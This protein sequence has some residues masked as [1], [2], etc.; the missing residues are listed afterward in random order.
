MREGRGDAYCHRGRPGTMRLHARA[1]G[2][3]S[4]GGKALSQKEESP[5]HL[6]FILS[7]K[8]VTP[9]WDGRQG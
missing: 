6:V 7:K 4:I 1:D 9:N 2:K 3:V 8:V 5:E